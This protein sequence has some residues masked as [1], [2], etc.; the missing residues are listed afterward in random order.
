METRNLTRQTAG[1]IDVR[2]QHDRGSR[3]GRMLVIG[4]L[5]V[6]A[7]FAGSYAG[8]SF[9]QGPFGGRGA[10][11]APLDPAQMDERIDRMVNHLA[12]KADAT[13]EQKERLTVI[14]K[15]AARDMAPLREKMR[16]TRKQSMTLLAAPV[17]DRVAIEKL[18]AEQMG[19]ADS[20]SRRMTQ[21]LA[22]AA[23]VL[24]PEQRMKMAQHAQKMGERHGGHRGGHR[25]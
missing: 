17:L 23:E 18:R 10:M 7:G 25:G 15:D 1:R 12:V 4:V 2:G 9:A 3:A 11:G 8:K 20:T 19:L 14:A 5:A 6:A 24:T 16:A 22:D 21:A 13:P